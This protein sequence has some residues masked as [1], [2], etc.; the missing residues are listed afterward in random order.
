L[1]SIKLV[2]FILR[3]FQFLTYPVHF[4]AAGCKHDSECPLTQACINRECQNPCS[5][6]QCG[7]NAECSVRNHRARCTCL[8]GHKGNPY[9]NCRQYECLTDSDC[10]TTLTCR[11]EKC[12]DP[13]D[14]AQNADCQP[15]N[16][17][18]IC[19][20]FPEFTGDPYGVA[21]VPSKIFLYRIFSLR[22]KKQI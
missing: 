16:H 11:K 10:S 3:D 18:G 4:V 6:E 1:G 20:C 9:E 12:V 22:P 15:R 5:F 17:R 14:C 21:C 8:P 2:Y 19:T 13:C 7:L